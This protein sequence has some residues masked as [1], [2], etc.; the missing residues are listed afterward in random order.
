M[1]QPLG[2]VDFA[3][4]FHMCRLHKSLY[5]LKQ[6]PWAWHT[7][8]SDFLISIDFYASK[9]DT[10]LF[11]L[12]V[13][14][15]NFYLLIYVDHIL[16]MSNNSTMLHRLIQLLSSEFKLHDLGV[17][18]YFLGIEVQFIVMGLML[19]HHKYIIDILTRAGMTFCKSV[20][21]PISTSKVTILSTLHGFVKL[22]VPFN[23]SH[24]R[25]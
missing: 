8:L 18:H 24:L 23:I 3:L 25:D 15:N 2:F 12:F 14:A 19:H 20:D 13:G 17:V 16:L 11:I 22:W 9:V 4:P 10:S 5:G 7:C 1:K 6:A 21:T